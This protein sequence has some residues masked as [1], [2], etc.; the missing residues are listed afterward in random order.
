MA[1]RVE[2]NTT[3]GKQ[4]AVY[5][6]DCVEAVSSFIVKSQLFQES[7]VRGNLDGFK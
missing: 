2:V 3:T 4:R 6:Q 5:Y 1:L 7:F